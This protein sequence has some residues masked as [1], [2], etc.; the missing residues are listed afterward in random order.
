MP[1]A[2]KHRPLLR[3]LEVHHER[4]Q[5]YHPRDGTHDVRDAEDV[6]SVRTQLCKIAT[7]VLTDAVAIKDASTKTGKVVSP[8]NERFIL[9]IL[10]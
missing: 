7:K 6:S 8:V 4:T 5:V 2:S 9:C 3:L 1:A 10:T